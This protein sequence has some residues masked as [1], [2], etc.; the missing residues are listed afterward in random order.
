MLCL[1]NELVD[2]FV[3]LSWLIHIKVSL[4]TH[5]VDQFFN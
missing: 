4:R 2:Y 1:R 3:V 5:E